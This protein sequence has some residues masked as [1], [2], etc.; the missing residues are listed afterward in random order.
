M[1]DGGFGLGLAS[2][3]S[4]QVDMPSITWGNSIPNHHATLHVFRLSEFFVGVRPSSAMF[5][6][7]HDSSFTC[8]VDSL[9]IEA[10]SYNSSPLFVPRSMNSSGFRVR[11]LSDSH[12]CQLIFSLQTTKKGDHPSL[13]MFW[14]GGAADEVWEIAPFFD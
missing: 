9:M 5:V 6:M 3:S 14:K 2:V 8:N 4:F 7:R 11:L 12:E 1:Q 10:R 13:L